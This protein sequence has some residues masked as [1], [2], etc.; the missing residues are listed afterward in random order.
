M[1]IET[2]QD[3]I[4]YLRKLPADMRIFTQETYYDD[5]PREIKTDD[6][7]IEKK[8]VGGEI[9]HEIYEEGRQS[10]TTEKVVLWTGGG[11]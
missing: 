6:F 5:T 2:V 11:H 3:L 1:K 8:E 9:H 10:V 7:A 4:A